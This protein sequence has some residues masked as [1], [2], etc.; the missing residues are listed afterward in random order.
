M[1]VL[2]QEAAALAVHIQ[3]HLKEVSVP[4]A[5]WHFLADVD[6]RYKDPGYAKEQ[7]RVF[8]SALRDWAGHDSV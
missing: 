8:E 3:R 4:E 5:V 2:S 7:L 1:R 6:I